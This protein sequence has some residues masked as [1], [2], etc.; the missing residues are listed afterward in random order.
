MKLEELHV[1][2]TGPGSV[3]HRDAIA[4][5][6]VRVT[7]VEVDLART[8]GGH[9]GDLRAV[10][11][12]LTRIRIQDIRA[13]CPVRPGQP[14]S[15]TGQQVD[16]HSIFEQLDIG[17]GPGAGQESALDLAAGGIPVVEHAAPG[18]ASLAS[19]GEIPV[20]LA[21]ELDPILQEGIDRVGAS[22][23]HEAD[24]ILPA[25]TRPG[26]QGVPDMGLDRVLVGDHRGDSALGEIRRGL[27]RLLLGDDDHT[28]TLSD[29][30]GV[31]Q[32]RDSAAE[33][34]DVAVLG[35][36]AQGE[37]GGAPIRSESWSES[38]SRRRPGPSPR[39]IVVCV[40]SRRRGPVPSAFCCSWPSM[41]RS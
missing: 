25:E 37:A 39:G 11:I 18:V 24:D 27:G 36:R 1:R 22:L 38:I 19:Q 29:A 6:D 15:P 13:E 20:F 3:G 8:T 34:E 26:V 14:R 32:A 41:R 12:D 35:V 33:D 17:V 21:I 30:E 10:A 23:D 5:R 31:E 9:E 16:G 28:G 40:R 7:G 4:G 2:H